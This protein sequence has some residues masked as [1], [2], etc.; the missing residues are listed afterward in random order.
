[1]RYLIT[2]IT[3]LAIATVASADTHWGMADYVGQRTFVQIS[4]VDPGAGTMY[5]L[6]FTAP[7]AMT[8]RTVKLDFSV[9][10]NANVSGIVGI[11]D[12]LGGNPNNLIG[13]VSP[14]VALGTSQVAFTL[15]ANAALS[16]GSVYHVR[17]DTVHSDTTQKVR[18]ASR[19]SRQNYNQP[20][21]TGL[22]GSDPALAGLY[23]EGN[24]P[25]PLIPPAWYDRQ[26][27]STDKAW[28]PCFGL[29][30]DEAGAVPVGGDGWDTVTLLQGHSS[31]KKAVG[32]SFILQNVPTA[33]VVAGQVETSRVRIPVIAKKD[34]GALGDL[35]AEIRDA[36]GATVLASG[37]LAAGSVATKV[38]NEVKLDQHVLLSVGTR[39]IVTASQV[40]GQSYT[41]RYDWGL[42]SF[43][44]ATPVICSFQG[45]QAYALRGDDP[46]TLTTVESSKDLPFQ[47]YI[48]E[49]ATMS[50]LAIGGLGVLLRKRR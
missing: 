49:P 30:S 31:G 42:E 23:W 5:S 11:Y 40:G 15:G 8:V 25:S 21:V 37:T 46:A 22:Q 3:L 35:K 44:V 2:A 27:G 28:D 33:Y 41:N 14:S 38:Y 17:L 43:G 20:L 12:D 9:K 10:K 47:L 4:D 50:L 45:T 32:E 39:Y 24:D 19:P 18:M 36:T 13:A 29:Y 26:A 34:A 7:N 6:R 16:A 1:M 48:P